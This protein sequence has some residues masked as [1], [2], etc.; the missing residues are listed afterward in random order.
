MEFIDFGKIARYS[1]RVIVTEKIDGTNG[2][3][4]IQGDEMKVGSRNRWL[5]EDSDNHGFYKWAMENKE[6]LM[7]L[8]DGR[9]F[10]EWWGQG[11]QRRYGLGEKR[12]SLFN[13]SLWTAENAPACC[14]VVPVLWAGNFDDLDVSKVLSDL[15]EGGSVASPGFKQPEGIIIYHTAGNL[16]FKKTFEKDS[17]KWVPED[18]R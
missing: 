12:F 1:R 13:T 15:Q 9:H 18:Q 4:F 6:E 7:K 8:G 16:Y 17:G 2:Q 14:H 10:G 5:S 11:I 3:I